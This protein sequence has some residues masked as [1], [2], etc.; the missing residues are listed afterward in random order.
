MRT[1]LSVAVA[2]VLGVALWVPSAQAVTCTTPP[3]AAVRTNQ[4]TKI[5]LNCGSGYAAATVT[6]QPQHGTLVVGA[7]GGPFTYTPASGYTGPDHFSYTA[8]SGGN[9]DSAEVTQDV[10]VSDDANQAPACSSSTQVPTVRVGHSVTVQLSCS[11]P[12]QDPLTITVT[13]P[14]AH[15]TLGPITTT[16]ATQTATY[17]ATSPGSDTIAYRAGDGRAQSAVVSRGFRVIAADANSLPVCAATGSYDAVPGGYTGPASPVCTDEDGDPLTLRQVT[18][19]T[20]GTVA[21]FGV[22]LFSY[23]ADADATGTDHFSFVANDGFGD[24]TV[25]AVTVTILAPTPPNCSE[26]MA[27]DDTTVYAG[28]PYTI[29]LHCGPGSAGPP[30]HMVIDAGPGHAASFTASGHDDYGA[31]YTYVPTTGYTGPDQITW[32]GVGPDGTA[33]APRTWSFT[34][35]SATNRPPTCAGPAPITLRADATRSVLITCV[36]HDAGDDNTL[37]VVTPPAHG[38]LVDLDDSN[39]GFL[40]LSYDPVDTYE[41]LDTFTVRI[42]DGH[43]GLSAPITVKA[44][45]LAPAYNRTP[46]CNATGGS[47]TSGGTLVLDRVCHDPDDDPLTYSVIR[48]PA[49]GVAAIDADGH[50]TYTAAAGYNGWDDF[51]FRVRDDHGASADAGFEVQVGSVTS[52]PAGPSGGSG[53]SGGGGSAA[54]TPDAAPSAGATGAPSTSVDPPAAAPPASSS[55]TPSAPR[56][57][58]GPAPVVPGLDLGDA[59]AQFPAAF[60]GGTL[61]VDG[62]RPTTVM[63]LRC[64]TA[65][66]VLARPVFVLPGGSTRAT[67]AAPRTVRGSLQRLKLSAGTR[68]KVVL[69]VPSA[70]R[71]RLHGTRTLTVRYGVTVVHADGSSSHG[72]TS[73]RVRLKR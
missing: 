63:T 30:I 69:R 50:V 23:H 43:G 65:C 53:S 37:T 34:V 1:A 58:P 22:G 10:V 72:T 20:K 54:A 46:I 71:R 39:D 24:S 17:T 11:D 26:T 44:S 29:R 60:S 49:H 16:G 5:P 51:A 35:T 48:Q 38:Q 18:A 40:T 64:A 36:D 28:V 42:S 59:T 62:T 4:A 47:T 56:P 25:M 3:S 61:A 57:G 31:D 70:L 67:A 55:T 27:P 19:P 66:T 7:F 8:D 9:D 12:N 14:P 13:T 32:H 45:V 6:H 41:G 33:S 68:G 73:F 21:Y 15:G 2:V 52:G